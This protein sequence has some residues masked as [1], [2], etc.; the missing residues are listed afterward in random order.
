[1]TSLNSTPKWM[2]ALNKYSPPSEIILYVYNYPLVGTCTHQVFLK[3]NCH[4]KYTMKC[5][6]WKKYKSFKS[7][8]TRMK[9]SLSGVVMIV[10]Q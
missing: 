10:K 3:C 8:T 2:H 9:D 5:N 6:G 4:S 1:M 7:T